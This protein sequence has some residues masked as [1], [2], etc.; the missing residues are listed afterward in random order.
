MHRCNGAIKKHQTIELNGAYRLI[1]V[2]AK[3]SLDEEVT[4]QFAC[5]FVY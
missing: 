5:C 4:K 3:K 2:L 1:R